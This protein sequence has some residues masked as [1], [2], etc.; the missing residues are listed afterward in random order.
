MTDIRFFLKAAFCLILASATAMAQVNDVELDDPNPGDQSCWQRLAQPSIGWGSIDVRYSRSQVAQ[1]CRTVALDAWKGERVSAQAVISTPVEFKC[2]R[3]KPGELKCGK[4]VIPASSVSTYF[5]RYTVGTVPDG[6]PTLLA[7]RLDPAESLAVPA[8][9]TRPLW[10]EVKVPSDA[11]A[12]TYKGTLS[13]ECDGKVTVLP[14]QLKV[15][16]RVLPEPFEWTFHLDL[17]Q[18]PYAV[19]RY[20]G[21]PLWSEEHF[22]HMRPIIKRY[23]EAGG[24]VITASVIQH[25]WNSQTFDPFESMVAKMKHPDGSWT[26]DYSIFDR[27]IEFMMS[28]G[29]GEQINCYTMVPWHNKFEYYDC[30]INCTRIVECTPKDA[31]YRELLLPFL[32]DFAAHLKAKGWFEITRIAMDERPEE[33]MDAAF[34]LLKEADPDFK[35]SGA[36]NYDVSSGSAD[37]VFDMSVGYEYELLSPEAMAKRK[38]KGMILTFYTCCNPK[39]PNTFPFSDPAESAFLGWHAAAVGYDGYLRWALCS[40]PEQPNQTCDYPAKNWP[41]GDTFILYP[42]GTSIR[43]ERLVEGIQDYEKIRIIRE[44][45]SEAGKAALDEVLTRFAPNKFDP[46]QK[47]EDLLSEGRKVLLKVQ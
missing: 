14:Y 11:K 36:A 32:K 6:T 43:F 28:C 19:A 25:P 24:K 35:I 4:A 40:W 45:A 20:F 16:D 9:S 38:S 12:G 44:T 46:S 3:M 5:V 31:A 29:L 30:S 18:N 37:R 33:M 21:V 39:R 13:V 47:A 41:T 23:V 26:F 1:V 27:W 10:I 7:D 17:W 8:C 22:E 15:A 42:T 34:A 2:V